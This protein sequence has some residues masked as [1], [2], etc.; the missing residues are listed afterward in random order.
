LGIF[1]LQGKF[2]D[3]SQERT[4]EEIQVLSTTDNGEVKEGSGQTGVV[5]TGEVTEPKKNT[6][7]TGN[8]SDP[9]DELVGRNSDGTKKDD[10]KEKTVVL[11]GPLGHVYTQALRI[12]FAREDVGTA[13]YLMSSKMREAEKQDK[14]DV[15][16]YVTDDDGL[17]DGGL[18][19]AT[20]CLSDAIRS[21]KYKQVVLSMESS[22]VTSKMEAL[23]ALSRAMGVKV[24][25][26]KESLGR[27]LKSN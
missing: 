2:G 21:G 12:A 19:L 13:M 11:D 8:D 6:D 17:E 3:F 27:L 25:L 5:V 15:Y 18:M 1:A 14:P 26:T 7:S 10:E 22:R 16:V 20:E 24:T 23:D 9:I 4:P